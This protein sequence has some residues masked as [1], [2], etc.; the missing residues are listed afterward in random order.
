MFYVTCN[1]I[2][3]IYVTYVQAD[4]RRSCTYGR[5]PKA[6]DISQGSL[7]CPSTDTGSP[8]L[9]GDSDTPPHLVAFYETLGIWR[10]YSRLKLILVRNLNFWYMYQELH[11]MNRMYIVNKHLLH[12]AVRYA[13]S[14]YGGC[15]YPNRSRWLLSTWF[16]T[17]V[18]ELYECFRCYFVGGVTETT[19]TYL[20]CSFI[21]HIHI[22][23]Y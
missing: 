23:I 5:A 7:T 16:P 6:I 18:P 20:N 14:I 22:S 19:Y 13:G 9:H 10:T 21:F 12:V 2:S 15:C 17:L 11:V 8:F 3:V 4:W 1:D